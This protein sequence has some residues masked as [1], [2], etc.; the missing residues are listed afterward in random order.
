MLPTR[1][2]WRPDFSDRAPLSGAAAN[3]FHAAVGILGGREHRG[4]LVRQITVLHR[5]PVV[6]MNCL[7]CAAEVPNCAEAPETGKAALGSSDNSS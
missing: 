4:W 3:R 6:S 7:T 1:I 5:P 2:F